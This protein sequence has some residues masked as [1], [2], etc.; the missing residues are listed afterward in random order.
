MAQRKRS[1]E[2]EYDELIHETDKA[3]LV[4]VDN[5]EVWIPLSQVVMWDE[6]EQ[7][8]EIPEWLAIEKNLV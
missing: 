5:G 3:R 1:V 4:S 7:V 6:D 8:F 2:V